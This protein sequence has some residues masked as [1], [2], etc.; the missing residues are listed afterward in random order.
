M[1]TSEHKLP[2]VSS[3]S[4]AIAVKSFEKASSAIASKQYD[5]AIKMLLECCRRDP[6]NFLFRK[7]LR[8]T[9]K[10]KFNNNLRGSRLAFLTTL[11]LR[12]KLKKAE[13]SRDHLRV[14]DL[15]EQILSKNPWDVGVQKD[16]AEAA[17][18]LGHLDLAV[19]LL[20]HA[21]QK[22]PTNATLNRMLA[23]LLEKRGNFSQAIALWQMVK[24]AVPSDVEA[25][26]KVKDLSASDTIKRGGYTEATAEQIAGTDETP[27]AHPKMNAPADTVDKSARE[28][29]ALL[30][31]IQ[32][33]PADAQLYLKLAELYQ[34]YNQPER[35]RATIEQ[36]LAPTG[37]DFRLA[38]ELME[39]DLEPFRRNISLAD[40]KIKKAEAGDEDPRHSI[41]DLRKIRAKL[42]KEINSREIELYRIRAER[43]P[44]DAS[45][46]LELG[47]RLVEGD[48][49][50]A[51]ITEYQQ[52]RKDARLNWK[53]CLQ[54]GLCFKKRN[55]W[56]LAQRNLEE[57]LASLPPNDEKARKEVLFQLASGLAEAGELQRA[58]DLGHDLAN[59]DFGYRQIGKLLDDWHQRLQ[60]A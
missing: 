21:R 41:E 55:N 3:D 15:G 2:T 44:Q 53:A 49:L 59:I 14:L 24:E 54:L 23:R 56:R 60:E 38:T 51:A 26:H 50:D 22:D 43:Y 6:G 18:S 10:E 52:V 45:Y 7:T 46:R 29:E 40:Q 42:V 5:Y 34:R 48:Q 17:D 37:N 28:I 19:F 25:D 47:N 35:A 12:T 1:G 31:R 27:L 33:N 13:H 4:R 57:A 9:Q 36:G 32:T 11:R 16:M 39:L 30:A 20:E 8:K 58:I